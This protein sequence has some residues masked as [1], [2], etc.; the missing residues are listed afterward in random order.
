MRIPRKA[1]P[2]V[3]ILPA[4]AM[5]GLVLVY[6]L[7]L[8]FY[9]SFTNAELGRR[10]ADNSLIFQYI[11]LGNFQRAVEDPA[12]AKS[13]L[14]TFLYGLGTIV[15]NLLIGLGGAIVLSQNIRFRNAFRALALLPW[16]IPSV[17]T[18]V[19]WLWLWNPSFGV[20]PWFV[21]AIGL[22]DTFIPFLS[23]SATALPAVTITNVWRTFP[24]M[25]IVVLAGL[26]TLPQE[27]IEAA[28]IDGAS[29]LRRF[30][31]ITMPHLR[32]YIGIAMLL[33]FMWSFQFPITIWIMT[34]GYPAWATTTIGI[35][36]YRVAF[37]FGQFAYECAIG[38]VWFV[39]LMVVAL[40]YSGLVRE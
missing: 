30:R 15:G 2:L 26:Q 40:L 10:A 36:A 18:A 31:Y 8:G 11:G 24:V 5:I 23:Q 25:L 35:Y 9:F 34:R 12:L 39:I 14:N 6:P 19:V 4:Y 1:I 28:M 21:S 27:Q 20:I 29:K 3:L 17:V 22:S 16:V 33:Q 32:Q 13:I 37:E 38:V 7:V